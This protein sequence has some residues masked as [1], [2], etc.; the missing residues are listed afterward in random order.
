ML[1]GLVLGAANSA[2]A[3]TLN[4]Y[5][6]FGGVIDGFNPTTYT[7][8]TSDNNLTLAIDSSC[9]I[10][11]WPVDN[12]LVGF[13]G[14]NINFYFPGGA[15][16]YIVFDNVHYEGNM[17]CNDPTNSNFWIYWAP[18]S[19]NNISEKCQDSM[20][21][22]DMVVKTNPAG[23]S[24]ATIG[25][26]FTYT[27]TAPKLGAWTIDKQGEGTF[28][29]IASSDTAELRNLVFADDLT[30][31]GAALTYVTNRAYLV[32]VVTNSRTPLNGGNPLTPG[33]SATW[34]AA[35]PGVTSDGT[36]HLVF[37][38]ENNP[39]LVSVPP[40]H[41]VDIE[42]TVAL[43]NDIT[44]NYPGRQFTNTADM[45]FD[46]RIAF[47]RQDG[48]TGYTDMTDLHAWPS[49]TL[50]MTIA[51]PNFVVNKSTTSTAVNP[52]NTITYTIDAQ[53][54]GG[55]EAWNVTLEDIIPQNTVPATAPPKGMC[56]TDPTT[57]GT[58]LSARILN[59]DGTLNRTLNGPLTGGSD[60]TL[61]WSTTGPNACKLILTL[62]DNAG[63]VELNQRLVVTYQ[64]KIDS[65]FI[66]GGSG[67]LINVAGAT[68]WF[69]AGSTLGRKE[70][71]GGGTG[72]L[73]DGTP[74]VADFQDSASVTVAVSGYYFEKTVSNLATGDDP[75]TA[76]APG[77]TLRYRLH[78]FNV[79]QTIRDIRIAD[80]LDAA[81][82]GLPPA[83]V[84][85]TVVGPVD[86]NVTPVCSFDSG[87]NELQVSG[88]GG[89][90]DLPI[91][92]DLVI[93]FDVILQA[94]LANGTIVSNQAQLR[95]IGITTILPAPAAYPSDDPNVNGVSSPDVLGDEDPTRVTVVTPGPLSKV[96]PADTNV[97][98]GQQFSYQITVPA[99]T[100]PMPLYDVQI[101]DTLPANLRFVS[102][103][104]VVGASTLALSDTDGGADNNLVLVDAAT[105]LDIPA[106]Q[107]AV[108][109]VT[110]E[111]RNDAL[112]QSGTTFQN[113]ATYAY[114][115]I[116]GTGAYTNGTGANTDP[117][118]VVEPALTAI[119][120]VS[121]VTS[122]KVAG[123]PAAAGDILEYT[124]TVPNGGTSTAFDASVVDLL[125]PNVTLVA[126]S[127]SATIGGGAVAGFVAAPATLASGALAWGAQNGD[128]SLDIPAGQSLV[129]TYRVTV[130]TVNGL[131]FANTV[132]VDWTSLQG[133]VA[134]ERTG[135]GCPATTAPDDYCFGPASAS[136]DSAD[137]SRIVKSVLAD[138]WDNGLSTGT[139][140][141]LRVG[142]T[143]DYRLELM[144]RDGALANV[145][146]SDALPVGLVF[147]SVV[148]INGDT[149]AAYSQPAGGA[150]AY[151]DIPAA[152]A[153]AAGATSLTWTLGDVT[154]AVGNSDNTFVIVYRARVAKDTLAPAATTPLTNNAA[155]TYTGAPA[156][157][158]SSAA[159]S[160][161]QPLMETPTKTATGF[162]SPAN[163][164]IAT[165]VI[166]FHLRS[167]NSGQAPAYN[168]TFTDVL[169]PQMNEASIS[170]IAVTVGTTALTAP[171]GY[172][173]SYDAATRTMSFA[174]NTPV[175][176]GECATIDYSIGFHANVAPN[177]TWS[178]VVTLAEYWSLATPTTTGQK[179]GPLSSVP[180][181]MTNPV[182]VT[183]LAKSVASPTNGEVTIGQQAVYTITVPGAP[184][185]AALSN[186]V[187]TDALD[188]VLEYAGGA[189]AVDQLGNPV[190]LT[191][192]SSAGNLSL[193]IAQIPAG[194]QV[195]ITLPT[196]VANAAANANAGYPFTNTASYSYTGM[197]A[198]A[199]T[200]GTSGTLTIV[201][202]L[203]AV[204]KSVNPTT[205][206]SAGQI[207]TYTVYLQAQ[208]GAN[209]SG[210]FDTSLVDGLSLGL[211]YVDGTATVGGSPNEPVRSGDGAGTP[212]TLTWSGIDIPEGATVAVVYQVRVLNTVSAGQTLTNS[213]TAS[214]TS[215]DGGFANERDG[216]GTPAYNDYFDTDAISLTVGDDTSLDKVYAGDTY[217]AD[218]GTGTRVG[219]LVEYELRM[220]LQEGS[221]TGVVLSDQLPT[222]MAYHGLVGITPASG[223]ANFSYSVGA[224]PAPGATG[225]INWNFG[226][227][228][229]TADGNAANDVLVVRYRARVL[230]ND[231]LAQTPATQTLINTATLAYT[232][233]GSPAAPKTDSQSIGVLQPMLSVTKS[234][235][236]AG[237]DA[238][239]GA[240]ELVTYTVDITNSGTAP[241]YDTVLTD[242]LPVGMRAGGA[243]T[244][245]VTLAG[246]PLAL[247]QPT[248]NAATGV[249]SFDFDSG[250]AN[251]YTIPPGAT[252]RVVYTVQADAT[253]GPGMTLTNAATASSYYSFDDE[254]VPADGIVSQRETYGP[255]NTDTTT[256]TTVTPGALSKQ[257]TQ[258]TATIGE[259]FKYRITVPSA[260]ID[261]ALHDVRIL[262]DISASAAR[263]RFV[264]AA[265]VAG[266]AWTL[267]NTS[268][269]DTNLVI[270]N[271]AGGIDIPA[272]GQ[273][274][275]EITVEVLD[276]PVNVDGLAFANTADYTYNRL[277]NDPATRTPGL[278]G[279]TANMTIV[280]PR[281]LTLDKSGPATM[282]AG[283]PGTFALNV[284]N[285]GTSRAWDI[286]VTDRLPNPVPGGM[287]DVAPTITS[288]Q[289][290][291]GTT[292]IRTLAPTDYTT[293]FVSGSPTCTFTF[294]GTSAAA[295][296]DPTQ[297][298]IITY[299]AQLDLDNPHAVTL[300]N[301]AGATQWFSRD[302]GGAGATGE[303]RTYTRA[304]SDGTPAVLDHEDAHSV[305]TEA[306]IVAVQKTVTNLTSPASGTNAKPG[307]R[308]RYT[309][310]VT[311]ASDVDM[312]D[313]SLL[314]DLGAL[315]S[316]KVFVP[317]SLTLTTVPAG[318]DT[319]ATNATGGTNNAGL[320]D[321]RSLALGAQGTPSDSVTVA[322]EVTL[323]PV[324]TS[325]T[326]VLNQGHLNAYGITLGHTDDP[327][328]NG[329]DNPAVLG[330]EDPTRTVITSAPQ[331][332]IL[333]TS[334][335]LTGDTNVL[336][337]G[338]TLRYTFAV[339][340]IGT[341]NATGVSMS[342]LIPAYTTYVANTTRLNGVAVADPSAGVSALRNGMLINA[343][344]DTTPGAMRADA[345]ATT[346]N[347]ATITFDVVINGDV[348]DGT[349]IANQGYVSGSGVGSGPLV[350]RPSDDPATTVLDDPTRDIVGNLP[351]VDAQKTVALAGDANGNGAV[352]EGDTL[353]Y[354][355]SVN[356][357]S[358]IPATGVVLTDGVPANT[359]YVAGSVKLNNAAVPDGGTSPLIAG[360]PVNSPGAA[361][362][363]VAAGQSAVVTFDVT[364]NAV[365]P[366]TVISNQGYVSTTGLPTEPTDADGIDSNGDQ[367]TTIV[368]GSAQQLLITKE[369]LVVGG[370]VAQAGGQLEYV[371]RVTNTGTTPAS[372]V[373]LTDDLSVL[374]GQA[375]YV[376]GS[377]TLNGS[378]VGVS[379]S[380]PVLTA[381]YS[382]QLAAGASATLRFRVLV[383]GALPVG[384]TLTNTAK[385]AWNTPALTAT[386]SVS[387]DI[388]GMPGSATLNGHA[389]HDVNFDNLHSTSEANLAGWTVALWRN[390]VQ[391]GSVTTDVGGLYRFSGLAPSATT[392]DQYELRFTAPGATT[393]TAKLGFADSVFTNGMQQISGIAAVSGSNLQNLN[394][395][396]DPNG[397]VFDSVTRAPIAGATLTMV[398][399]GSTT[400]LPGSCFDDPVQ[401]NQVTLASGFYKFS[402]TYGDASCPVGGDY[403]INV[404][405]PPTGYVAGPSK[406]IPPVTSAATASYDVASCTGDAVTAPTGYCEA[407]VSA[408]APAAA[409]PAAQVQHYLHLTLSNPEPNHSQLFNNSIALDPPLDNAVT[410]SKR[411]ALVNVSR[412]Q[413]VPYTITVK[414]AVALNE[415]S[416]V[417]TFPPGFKYVAGSARVNGL[418]VEP[419]MTNRSLTWPNLVIDSNEQTIKLLFI[420]GSGVGEGDYVNRAQVFHSR[421]GP[422][423]GEATATVRVVP[424]PTFDCTDIIG[425]VFDDA[426]R[427]GY[428]DE[429]EKG[430]PGVRVAT[431]RG[432]LITTDDHG[433]FHVTCAVVPDEDRG[434][435]FI[436][437][438]DDRTLPTGYRITTENP[439]VQRVTRGKMAKFNFGATIHKVVRLDVANGVF[440]PGTTEM[441]LQWKPRMDQLMGELKKGPSMLRLAYMAEIEDEKLVEARL[442][443]MKQ[444]LE[445]QWAQQNGAYELVIETEVFWRTGAPPGRS[446]LK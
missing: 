379:Y 313:F 367:P 109:T 202:P 52:S 201:E 173:Y 98:I 236:A 56:E 155:L 61:A 393:T 150:F 295:A 406:L 27:I 164:N 408:Y 411:S 308:L 242:V 240:G 404:T 425:K 374:A 100:V 272:N 167:C 325:A 364:V 93:E 396:I 391:L 282:R 417:D 7:R 14:T 360:V 424:D 221:T 217:A 340:N 128:G 15:D 254:A 219:D 1:F 189:T 215:L 136:I 108:V 412:G 74:G 178:N 430:L 230:N 397:V 441:R 336:M 387:I 279:T 177:Q 250:V 142:D 102:A 57:H 92:D 54:T 343:P 232:V 151:A 436:M 326:V 416:I 444:E 55:W 65:S 369:V 442:K 153:P 58:G 327:T 196:R 53:N 414:N 198:G 194:G 345:S 375:S 385:V 257:N 218:G 384:T 284:Q 341:E 294:T 133:A 266:G 366:S 371:V 231:A 227:V 5:A 357:F 160:V 378:T 119:K 273:A 161:R 34:L 77:D 324:I 431:A 115:R 207:L 20:V 443:M 262:D 60:Y 234:A 247:K 44:T 265:V 394:L 235:V 277:P 106:N 226:T 224:Q 104:A 145:V 6:D 129:L 401:Q 260:P 300:T 95:A 381:N 244:T 41:R 421:L 383:D 17:S 134:A 332:Q 418:A 410:I 163:V 256:L 11:N 368:V 405:P 121:N 185:N 67:D 376:A 2:Q 285:T 182:T 270:E 38:Y 337:A 223:S 117:M 297:R 362:G 307:D 124:V 338:D 69:N 22:V 329:A 112:N 229:N 271:T 209:L 137:P 86:V 175:N 380:A 12:G 199:S 245:S 193:T 216:S 298:L 274:V 184:V 333:K 388:G 154:N 434:S 35:H 287:C 352:D 188:G 127:V 50:P 426:N 331:F 181:V 91:G 259:Q 70:F 281:A 258:P 168:A 292:L 203:V 39:D 208:S 206:S 399:A 140:A 79:D 190:A 305:T 420:V 301:V 122:G 264:S 419:V 158:A 83:I 88:S 432:L 276:D 252:L 392:A 18:G 179:Y 123:D 315:N 261:T 349:L 152:N 80:P 62:T 255:S 359:S 320:V 248:Y 96:N 24:A 75:A 46:K 72:L 43:D 389:W 403:V 29:E 200:S 422:V 303:T 268:G 291:D 82:F 37:S 275:I 4:C 195:T 147:D 372:Q 103:S 413:L 438:V 64:T 304:V 213:A 30:Q 237:G 210:A 32:N 246:A 316:A 233:G 138:A 71:L 110:V 172:T 310:Q 353:R 423:S 296:I 312:P 415:L 141:A 105:G 187:V 59:P 26:P 283:L 101:L 87:T 139:D 269:S 306:A 330:D 111:V 398:R 377:A 446:A 23:Q 361:S 299:N 85:C 440:E 176:P 400:A 49:T 342:D 76:A 97:A 321:I 126:G 278:P 239:I 90:L 107:Q 73:T 118:T 191:D 390:N 183:P 81:S 116:N 36:K 51:A 197:P 31:A 267:A 131:P 382:G 89:S 40:G 205:V 363:T 293:N 228:V 222:G 68:R 159:I 66:S 13:P 186:V 94:G 407:Q 113:T 125:P 42:L 16:Y 317:G 48:S 28:H 47:T 21:P 289:I 358:A 241:A 63:A 243:T 344:E 356:N 212:Q 288:V 220:G 149:T 211:Q 249:A 402:L 351:L 170:G 309:I 143:V 78:L 19:F 350:E 8:I 435:N 84:T 180:F 437:K 354:T 302:T 314:D 365:A 148:S 409:V 346:A 166:P 192:A 146:V 373:V 120:A 286:T 334:Q 10:K 225:T 280:E 322:F 144:L 33:A 433:R 45:W 174:L 355:I 445:H 348:L 339:K 253:L 130:D 99:T 25:V 328:V 132:H 370:G 347:V 156:G 251:A 238:V 428:Q 263:L 162:T 318:A 323:A 395:P 169:A 114:R 290:F 165:D 3:G 335:D 135:D 429:G 204:T 427:N 171:A 439:R 386:A 214:W 9:L 157:L 319:S 311:N